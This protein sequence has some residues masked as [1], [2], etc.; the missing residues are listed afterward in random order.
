MSERARRTNA[1]WEAL[2]RAQVTLIRQFAA[3][4]IWGE[5]SMREYDVLYT[6][7]K[8]RGGMRLSE[9]N[10]AVLLSQPALSRLVDRLAER[11]LLERRPDPADGRGVL[12]HLTDEGRR[13]QRRVGG[14]HA[15]AVDTAVGSALTDEELTTLQNL[16]DRL[17]AGRTDADD[18][19][20]RN[21]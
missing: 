6:V 9:L 10:R 13:L 11:G 5:L 3:D 19:E 2:L 14:R 4:D 18:T 1:A 7:S 15:I 16:C 21:R 20:R 12:V 8:T 17:A